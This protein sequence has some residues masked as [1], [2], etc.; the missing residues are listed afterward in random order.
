MRRPHRKAHRI[1]WLVLGPLAVIGLILGVTSRDP[2]PT[3]E[4]PL[5]V[6]APGTDPPSREAEEK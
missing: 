4:S 2:I 1:M 3:Q 5:S 6:E